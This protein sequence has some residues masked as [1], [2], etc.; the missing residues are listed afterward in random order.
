MGY[1]GLGSIGESDMAWDLAYGI[2]QTIAKELRKGLKEKS[3]E[4][5]TSGAV[6]V[7]LFNESVLFPAKRFDIQC[8]DEL[9]SVLTDARRELHAELVEC[10][11]VPAEQW[12]NGKK[13]KSMHTNAYKRLLKK[14]DAVIKRA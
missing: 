8:S 10:E 9:I 13:G 5:N 11:A 14:L 6:N 4:Y 12:R 2:L 7:A 3:N 1:M